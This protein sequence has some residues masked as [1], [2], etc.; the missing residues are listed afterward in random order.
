M[1]LESISMPPGEAAGQRWRGLDAFR[2]LAVIGMLLVNNPGD[3]DAVYAQLRH[4]PWNGCTIADL[5]FPFFLFVVGI[6]T[7]VSLASMQRRGIDPTSR[8]WRRA[9]TIFGIGLLLNWFPFY[10]S[11][12][13]GSITHVAAF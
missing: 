11:G 5:V 6:T 1:R 9:V 4:S 7:T 13:V 8:I 12:H 10:Q 2:G 3:R